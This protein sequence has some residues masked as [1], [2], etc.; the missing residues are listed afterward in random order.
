MIINQDTYVKLVHTELTPEHQLTFSDVE[1]QK[2][3][4]DSLQGLVLSGFTYQRK[5]NVIRYPSLFDEVEKY[6]YVVYHN[7][8][9]DM[10]KKYYYAYI[11]DLK[12]VNNEMTEIKIETDVFQTWQFDYIFK[13]SFVERKHVTDD[14]AG[15]YTQ[16]EPVATGEYVVNS[17]DYYTPFDED[18]YVLQATEVAPSD[19]QPTGITGYATNFGSIPMAGYTYMFDNITDFRNKIADYNAGSGGGS[20]IE[21][22]YNAYMIPKI[23]VDMTQFSSVVDNLYLGQ[24]A[25]MN[26][27]YSVSKPSTL[28]DYIPHNQKLFTFPYCYLLMSNNNGSNNILHYEKFRDSECPFYISGIPTTNGSVKCTPQEYSTNHAYIEEEGIIAGKYPSLNWNLDVYADWLLTNSASLNTQSTMGKITFGLGALATLGA[29]IGVVVASAGTAL[30]ALI[31]MGVAG[32]GTMLSGYGQVQNAINQDYEHSLIPNS[33]TGLASGGDINVAGD[34]AGFF[35]YKY[36]IKKE[37]AEIIDNY[38]DMYGYKVNSMEVPNLHTRLN[39][40]FL[41]I[42]DPNV[43][44]TDVPEKD[45]NKFKQMLT[46]GITFW[47]N[48][49]TFRDYSQSNPN[50]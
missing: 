31:G 44:S 1:A 6:N 34:Q 19:T 17:Y 14:I 38:F 16:L 49:L 37:Y 13:K 21:A 47:H 40:N 29:T 12:Y 50:V 28:D 10:T 15:N 30:P 22:I 33:A 8:Y 23:C 45:I 42:I 26:Y 11:T 20:R 5:D 3:Y 4:F 18:L 24:T 48:P 27:Q 9:N 7:D 35:F 36:S 46:A 39:W 25:P 41:K 2:A 43:E 32:A